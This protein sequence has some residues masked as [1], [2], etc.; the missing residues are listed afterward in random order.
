MFKLKKYIGP[1]RIGELSSG[2]KTPNLVENTKDLSLDII[3]DINVGYT[4][5]FENVE[6]KLYENIEIS[7]SQK[8]IGVCIPIIKDIKSIFEVLGKCN[9]FDLIIL[10]NI[11]DLMFDS[12]KAAYFLINLR[13]NLSEGQLVYVQGV[14]TPNLGAF[15]A[16]FGIDLIDT[17]FAKIASTKGYYTL[18][19][20]YAQNE[21]FDSFDRFE[22]ALY[23]F[24]VHAK[25]YNILNYIEWISYSNPALYAILKRIYLNY[26]QDIERYVDLDG[27]K[28]IYTD[29]SFF[30]PNVRQFVD[31]VAKLKYPDSDCVLLIPCTAKKP[32]SRSKTMQKLKRNVNK[33]NFVQK[34]VLTSPLGVVPY[35][36]QNSYP[37]NSYDIPVTGD[38][39]YEEKNRLLVLLD[40]ILSQYKSKK[41]ICHC[42]Q[43]YLDIC[44]ELKGYNLVFT[45]E[46][47]LTSSLDSLNGELSECSTKVK[48][49]DDLGVLFNYQFGFDSHLFFEDTKIV[50]RLNKRI[51]DK[52]DKILATLDHKRGLFSLTLDGAKK[53]SDKIKSVKIDFNLKSNTVFAVGVLDA[54]DNIYI[55]DE[56]LIKRNEKIIGVGTAHMPGFVM[57]QSNSGI[58]VKVRHKI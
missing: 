21:I 57:R 3:D 53:I 45:F 41:I 14:A 40:K 43:P 16:Y 22:K 1:G 35:Q 19:S 34:F 26:Y 37:A 48:L 8:K 47:K 13:K 36:L 5:A 54:S 32:Y 42:G 15:L 46:D 28:N 33:F 58:A 25:N 38:W 24:R 52:N 27:K 2:V 17:S 9:D 7:K 51:L 56:V 29:I 44:K 12:K 18:D 55:G 10:K 20:F 11:N 31:R 39:S 30:R 23:D 6:D 4:I 50:G 49:I